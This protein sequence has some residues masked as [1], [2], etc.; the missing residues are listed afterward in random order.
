MMKQLV[1]IAVGG[2]LGA[3]LRYGVSTAVHALAGRGFPYGTLAVN[4]AG[5]AAMGLLFV[6]L[7]ERLEVDA[8]WRAALLV[9]LLGSFTTFSTF[10]METLALIEEG[11]VVKALANI[12]ASVLLCLAGVWLGV[13]VGRQW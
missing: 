3:V 2:A 11:A 10:S 7:V 1:A 6:L 5:S 8:V 9:G 12:L 4:V 13:A